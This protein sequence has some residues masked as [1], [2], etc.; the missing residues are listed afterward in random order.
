MATTLPN[1]YTRKPWGASIASVKENT[2]QT[3]TDND[4]KVAGTL[5]EVYSGLAGRDLSK[6]SRARITWLTRATEYQ[7]LY[8]LQNPDIFSAGIYKKISAD[9]VTQEFV[10][11]DNTLCLQARQCLSHLSGRPRV[12]TQNVRLRGA[13]GVI[14]GKP[15]IVDNDDIYDDEFGIRNW[16]E[17][18]GTSV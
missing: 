8:V 1:P 16:R 9:G 10:D 3:V 12:R 17:Y 11:A 6:W 18:D 13:T 4:I 2:N 14:A 5:I 7:A 15:K